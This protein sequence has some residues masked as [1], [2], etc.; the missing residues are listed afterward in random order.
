M[1]E[2]KTCFLESFGVEEVGEV[3]QDAFVL[4]LR[5]PGTCGQWRQSLWLPGLSLVQLEHFH[6]WL[7]AQSHPACGDLLSSWCGG[8]LVPASPPGLP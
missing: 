6:T 3:G 5:A 8:W 2:C 1:T 7:D 4:E